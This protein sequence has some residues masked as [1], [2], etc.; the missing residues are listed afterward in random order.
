MVGERG[1]H[2][3]AELFIAGEK[4]N[5]CFLPGDHY[6]SSNEAIA[7]RVGEANYFR[8][9]CL[10]LIRNLNVDSTACLDVGANVGITSLVMGQLSKNSETATPISKILSFEP[11]P[12]TFK[13]LQQNVQIFSNLI[14]PINCA[15]GMRS[16]NLSFSRTPITTSASHIV[17][18]A[19]FTD[20]ANEVVQAERLDYY[21]EKL[22]LPHVGLIKI[23]VEGYEKAV[24]EGAVGTIEKFNPWIVLEFNSWTLIA[25]G[26]I[27]PGEFLEYLLNWFKIVYKVNK[28]TGALEP[29][30]SKTEAFNFLHNNLVLNGCLDDLVLK[31]K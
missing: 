6:L 13:C 26:G 14:T 30:K 9:L 18:S 28:R 20:L 21:V 23:D 10:E 19:H 2:M 8:K 12:R 15:L 29:I 17:T 31:L 16:G 25:F 5:L 3:N 11:E 24:L 1:H 4:F 27:N 22:A 7:I